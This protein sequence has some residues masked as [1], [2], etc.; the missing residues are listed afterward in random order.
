MKALGFAQAVYHSP[1]GL[2]APTGTPPAVLAQLHDAFKAAMFSPRHLSELQRYDQDASYLDST[3][4]RQMLVQ[5]SLR[6][7]KLLQRMKLLAE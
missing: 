1:W 7:R 4:Y 2:V 5:S 3:A 6:E